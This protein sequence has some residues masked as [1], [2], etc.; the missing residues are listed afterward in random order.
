MTSLL[1]LRVREFE[2]S[3]KELVFTES[4]GKFAMAF[5]VDGTWRAYNNK[6][7][8]NTFEV[9]PDSADCHE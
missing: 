5:D 4:D 6:S 7:F 1:G 8:S 3:S 2:H 9:L